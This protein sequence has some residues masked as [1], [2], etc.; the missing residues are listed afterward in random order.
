MFYL[1]RHT[2]LR[3][4]K[5]LMYLILITILWRS[6]LHPSQLEVTQLARRKDRINLKI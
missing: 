1:R 2:A 4:L 3:A 6:I 5:V